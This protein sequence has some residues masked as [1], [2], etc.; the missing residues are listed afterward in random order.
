MKTTKTASVSLR[1]AVTPRLVDG[2]TVVVVVVVVVAAGYTPVTSFECRC[3]YCIDVSFTK[4]YSLEMSS[5]FSS[6]ASPSSSPS[7][8]SRR[9]L[10]VIGNKLNF[11]LQVS[12]NFFSVTVIAFDVCIIV[13]VDRKYNFIVN[14]IATA[15]I[16]SH[17]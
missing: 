4:P 5:S 6:P 10:D 13:I 1:C 7:F 9:I 11:T 14:G 3:N 8:L 17:H 15:I 12:P 2:C 16:H